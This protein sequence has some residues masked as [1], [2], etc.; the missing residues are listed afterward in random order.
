MKK[1]AHLPALALFFILFLSQSPARAQQTARKFIRETDFLLSLPEGYNQDTLKRWPLLLFLHGSG[2][3]G[4]DL[5]KVKT[6]G[7][8]MLVASG[9][10]LPFIIVSPQAPAPVGWE[11]EN[12]YLL[13]QYVKNNYRADPERIY[14]TGLSMGGFGTW[15]LA[16]KH[17]EEF[18]AIIPICGGG[19]TSEAWKLRN[20]PIWCFHGALDNSVP[21]EMDQQMV[22]AVKP[23]NASVYFTVYPDANHNSWERTYNNDSIYQWLLSKTL[24]RYRQVPVNPRD[25]RPLEGNYLGSFGDSVNISLRHDSLMVK[26]PH[27]V[28]PLKMGAGNIFFINEHMAIDVR[29]IKNQ[30]GKTAGFWLFEQN[31]A[32]YRKLE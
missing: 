28:F 26:T 11:P 10:K 18:A 31:R 30:A 1:S 16:M 2:E 32:Y 20:T 12:L 8:P 5:E 6:H 17:P 14:L 21:V 29:F 7:P 9:R 27:G 19:D 24:F 22:N 25:L 3:S 23:F 15:T 4:S 13:L